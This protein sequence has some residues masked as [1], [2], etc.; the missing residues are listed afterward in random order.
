MGGCHGDNVRRRCASAVRFPGRGPIR[1]TSCIPLILVLSLIPH[2][3]LERRLSEARFKGTVALAPER[4]KID[5]TQ[6][7][8]FDPAAAKEVKL[9]GLAPYLF[10]LYKSLFDAAFRR[11]SA[12]NRRQTL[13]A[14]AGS[15][16]SLAGLS[17]T[18]ILTIQQ[19]RTSAVSAGSLVMAFR[20]LQSMPA[21]A[22]GVVRSWGMALENSMYMGRLRTLVSTVAKTSAPQGPSALDAPLETIEVSAISFRYPGS[23]RP[24]LDGVNLTLRR[25]ETVA[26]VGLNGAGKT[27]LAK[28][29]LGLYRPSDG[30]L[31]YNGRSVL[32]Y[33]LGSLRKR[34]GCLFQDFVK[35]L[36]T[37]RDNVAF[38]ADSEPEEDLIHRAIEQAGATDLVHTAGGL[39]AQLGK[40]FGGTD[41]SGGEWQRLAL[42]RALIRDADF[43]VLDEL[44]GG[45]GPGH[46]RR[47]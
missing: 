40:Q 32:E 35:Y 13:F 5:Y 17:A 21:Y 44:C 11:Q 37:V 4:R 34:M 41:L 12:I 28:L 42:A 2:E 20:A 23:N 31:L 46:C 16:L 38:G 24:A 27:T 15:L 1:H 33:D 6:G 43:L 3:V 14:V 9:F 39:D 29:L 22:G 7:L 18:V 26:L 47:S 45:P 30:N 36:L 8:L 25:G 19:F 10:D